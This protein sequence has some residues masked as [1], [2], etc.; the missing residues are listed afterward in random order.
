MNTHQ[1]M[2]EEEIFV[3]LEQESCTVDE[4][5]AKM[6]GWLRPPIHRRIIKVT[7]YGEIPPD[8]LL[9]MRHLPMPLEELLTQQ[10]EMASREFLDACDKYTSFEAIEEKEKKLIEWDEKIK[11][12]SI[13]K[14]AIKKEL[15]NKTSM[16]VIDQEAT[17]ETG[18]LQINLDS[19]YQF[20]RKK[21]GIA[22]FDSFEPV[23]L[24]ENDPNT[25]QSPIPLDTQTTTDS[26][27][28]NKK[29][30][31]MQQQEHAILAVLRTF[32]YDLMSL[33]ISKQGKKGIRG[34]IFNSLKDNE[35]F[36]ANTSFKHTWQRL[37]DTNQIAY[38]K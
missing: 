32:G 9:T 30:S 36:E 35:L 2:P 24:S 7:P 34:R 25:A 8:Y 23:I 22:I 3:D 12:A 1:I 37:L 18:E 17:D 21:F 6:L 31:I 4:A 28:D 5:V 33:P 20:A 29:L 13:Y 11:K 14:R 16:L 27:Q 15:K 10:R 38:K 19:L 26:Q